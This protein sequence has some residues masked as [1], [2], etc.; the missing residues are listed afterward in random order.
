MKEQLISIIIPVYNVEKYLECCLNSVI[1]QT[2]HNLEILL[3]ND[4]STDT[5]NMICKSFC[6]KDSRFIYFEHNNTGVSFTRNRALENVHGEYVCFVD[7]DDVLEK[8][9]IEEQIKRIENH[10][11]IITRYKKI[12]E[13]GKILGESKIYKKCSISSDEMIKRLFLSLKYGYQGYIGNKMFK[14]V[15]IQ[16]Y[17]I[18]FAEDV[19]YNE[20]R[21]FVLEYLLHSEKVLFINA[22]AYY[23]R[24]HQNNATAYT[25]KKVTSKMLT[26]IEAFRKMEK[27][28]YSAGK[29][30]IYHIYG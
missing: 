13:S 8:D 23:Y 30:T 19:Y 4:G 7:A 12:D 1:S 27:L 18:R 28:L 25:E 16:K 3:V 14:N 15:I 6:K 21:L 24:I 22:Y 29:K 26:E 17:K 10:D 20:D 5:S 9:A 2:Y 11:M